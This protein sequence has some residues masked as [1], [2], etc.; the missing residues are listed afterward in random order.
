MHFLPRVE[1]APEAR[2]PLHS[3]QKPRRGGRARL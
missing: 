1:R 2:T 3:G